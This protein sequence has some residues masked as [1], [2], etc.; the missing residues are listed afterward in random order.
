MTLKG[1]AVEA[2]LRRL[3]NVIRRLRKLQAIPLS[4][5]RDDEDAQWLAERGL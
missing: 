2:R 3:Q 4:Q 5:F 1:P